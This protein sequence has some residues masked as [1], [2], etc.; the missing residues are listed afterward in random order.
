MA[1]ELAMP[2]LSDSME[3]GTV[4]EWLVQV[5]GS[6]EAGQ[7]LVEIETD[8]ATIV[9]EAETAGTLVEILVQE[10]ESAAIG[11]P[12][13][14]IGSMDDLAGA[15]RSPAADSE[16]PIPAEA[17]G[18]TGAVAP[19]TAVGPAREPSGRVNAS[20]VARRMAKELGVDLSSLSGSGP[21][22]LITREDVEAAAV[23]PSVGEAA[24]APATTPK[25]E[26]ELVEPSSLQRTIARRMVEGSERPTFSVEVEVDMTQCASLRRELAAAG[27]GP[28]FNDLVV[29]AVALALREFPRLNGSYTEQGFE[30]HSRIN[31]GI[32]VATDD[33]LIVPTIFDADRRSLTTIA[34]EA[35]EL[36]RKVRDRT[37]TPAELEGG[38]FT[39]SNLGMLGV[40]RFFP[41]VNPPQTAILGVGAVQKRPSVGDDGEIVVRDLMSVTVVCDHRIVYGAEAAQFLARL[42]EL[43]ESPESLTCG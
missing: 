20:P 4:L 15:E 22:G 38:T 16:P 12:I 11:A 42:R 39:V 14:R 8:K 7:P 17:T 28:S 35:I 37:V 26:T 34:R 33:G 25:G 5:G 2:R 29:K 27:E 36:A 13:A 6:V 3:E 10:G 31:V 24:A 18:S 1:T 23:D 32:A 19:S 9:Y 40:R 30:L 43:L 41:I 21:N